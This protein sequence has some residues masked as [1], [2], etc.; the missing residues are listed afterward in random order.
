MSATL[1]PETVDDE[2]F[3]ISSD[4]LRVRWP[5]VAGL[6]VSLL[7]HVLI[8]LVWVGFE[9]LDLSDDAKYITIEMVPETAPLQPPPAPEPPKPPAPLPPAPPLP[10]AVAPPPPFVPPPIQQETAPSAPQS[11]APRA[12]QRAPAP[13]LAPAPQ[14]RNPESR[15]G[16]LAP[17]VPVERAA[18]KPGISTRTEKDSVAA[19][20]AGEK[21][22]QSEVDFILTQVLRAWLIDYRSPRFKDITISGTFQLNPDGTLGSPFGSKDPWDLE[23]MIANYA[24]LQ[25]PAARDQ[26]T[27]L[28][29]FLG[30]MRQAQPFRRQPDAPPM[31]GPKLLTFAFRLGDL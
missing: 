23:R 22:S 15:D 9:P 26:R 20:P 10:P 31:T 3:R 11:A 6:I 2:P 19:A 1:P 18:P 30:A 28:E 21:V 12:A 13:V 7:L 25:R 24:E 27:A 4:A 16:L 17:N 14:P 8:G 5:V 29:S